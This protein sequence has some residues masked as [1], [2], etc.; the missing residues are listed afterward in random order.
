MSSRASNRTKKPSTK[1]KD[2]AETVTDPENGRQ[3]ESML[4]LVWWICVFSA[5][6]LYRVV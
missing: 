5:R 2:N 3:S 6:A 4:S 1:V